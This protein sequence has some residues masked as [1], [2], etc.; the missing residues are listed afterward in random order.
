MRRAALL[1]LVAV[2]V[3]FPSCGRGAAGEEQNHIARI[4]RLGGR[5]ERDETKPGKPVVGVILRQSGVDADAIKELK[6]FKEL[7]RL[8]LGDSQSAGGGEMQ[9]IKELTGL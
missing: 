9:G 8:D 7:K 4:Q 6:A 3:G 1:G 2:V 5:V